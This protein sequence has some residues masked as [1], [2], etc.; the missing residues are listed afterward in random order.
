MS[1]GAGLPSVEEAA[2]ERK[3]HL[4]PIRLDP[5]LLAN[6]DDVTRQR[7]LDE[8]RAAMVQP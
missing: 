3:P 6:L 4:R 2:F 8:W 7:F 1:E 5:G